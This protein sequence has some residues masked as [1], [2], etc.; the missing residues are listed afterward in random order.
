MNFVASNF[1]RLDATSNPFVELVFIIPIYGPTSAL[2]P[3][4]PFAIMHQLLYFT[5]LSDYSPVNPR[6][7]PTAFRASVVLVTVF[8][9]NSIPFAVILPVAPVVAVSLASVS[10]V[11]LP[12]PLSLPRRTEENTAA[13]V[14]PPPITIA[15]LLLFG[16][17]LNNRL[18]YARWFFSAKA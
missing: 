14:F 7:Q 2:R 13:A 4:S 5:A 6:S 12:M 1:S 16:A 17:I 9:P 11:R 8:N 3:H 10:L 18:R 15:F